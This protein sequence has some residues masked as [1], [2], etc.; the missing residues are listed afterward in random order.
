MMGD[1]GE[2]AKAQS[3]PPPAICAALR[4]AVTADEYEALHRRLV[5]SA[6]ARVGSK[7]ASPSQYR[8][9][10]ASD[11]DYGDAALRASLRVFI[12][13][14]IATKLAER[15]IGRLRKGPLPKSIALR[16]AS[17]LATALLVHRALRRFFVRLRASVR[18]DEA[19]PFR[20]RN[21]RLAALLTSRYTT[22]IGPSLAGLSLGILPPGAVRSYAA[23]WLFVRALEAA[24][25]GLESRWFASVF[26]RFAPAY[27]QQRPKGLPAQTVWPAA[28]QVVDALAQVAK[29]R[30][31]AFASPILHPAQPS[32]SPAKLESVAAITNPAH[33][34]ISS[35]SCALLHPRVTSCLNVAVQQHLLII[36]QLGRAVLLAHVAASLLTLKKTAQNPVG[37][38]QHLVTNV[39]ARTALLSTVISTAWAS[40]C[41]FNHH[42]PRRLLPT[43]RVYLSGALAGLPFAALGSGYRGLFLYFFRV[44]LG[45][46]WAAGKKRR[47]FR[48]VKHG[49]LLIISASWAVLAVL[50][51]G[52]PKTV[53]GTS[54]RKALTWCQGN[55][56][57]DPVEVARE[58]ARMR[59]ENS[60]ESGE[61]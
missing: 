36:P 54:F 28:S 3:R 15:A 17:A 29:L 33:P 34:S 19:K 44:A 4:I 30:W 47:L 55:G 40:I 14:A 7:I 1:S 20:E 50:L 57:V 5:S 45:S 58:R 2:R 42:F 24:Y 49:D 9:Y 48:A 25:N 43:Q 13:S 21:P 59:R 32:A 22:A 18:S 61:N 39:M 23:L 52:R 56:F 41:L 35:L 10:V 26:L 11:H 16:L 12:G 46:F 8:A 51:N 37:G 6:P 27:V 31:P 38:L 53:S 60:G